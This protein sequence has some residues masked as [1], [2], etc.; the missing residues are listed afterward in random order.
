MESGK[1]TQT[2]FLLMDHG[3]WPGTEN[4]ENM[5]HNNLPYIHEIGKP[6]NIMIGVVIGKK[7]LEHDIS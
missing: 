1:E 3:A 2:G 4:V 7:I 5:H 6:Q